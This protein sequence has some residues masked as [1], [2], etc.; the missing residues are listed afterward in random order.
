[1]N[2]YEENMVGEYIL[3]QARNDGYGDI[4]WIR[5]CDPDGDETN[6]VLTV[7][8]A[9]KLCET[10]TAVIGGIAEHRLESERLRESFRQLMSGEYAKKEE[11]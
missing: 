7:E 6:I 8:E 3:V 2:P 10:L 5:E 9:L 4:I 1:M 11:R